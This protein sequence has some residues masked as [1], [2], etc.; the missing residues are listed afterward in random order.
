MSGRG[1]RVT[2]KGRKDV[3]M[4]AQGQ[5]VMGLP[6]F[7]EWLMRP[8]VLAQFLG[9]L[10]AGLSPED[11]A[12]QHRRAA[13]LRGLGRLAEAEAVYRALAASDP[14]DATAQAVAAILGGKAVPA[15]R[16]S[17]TPFVRLT[18]VLPDAR[19]QDLWDAVTAQPLLPAAVMET[20][21]TAKVDPTQR[22]A[23]RLEDTTAVQAWF[24][25]WL[26]AFAA[27]AGV[28]E[29]LGLPPVP[30]DRRELHVTGH[31]DGG[32][33]QM[34]RDAWDDPAS[35]T[36][37]RYV[38]YVYYFHRSPPV[39]SG[40]DLLVMDGEGA[41]ELR[42]TRLV[43]QHNSIVF[44]SARCLHGVRPVICPSADIRDWRW[45]VHGW[46]HMPD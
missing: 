42:F 5:K 27:E 33:L 40:G 14:T 6:A 31:G 12:G 38:A 13:L 36:H 28:F 1:V 3:S 46:L 45:A 23:F 32:F 34:H 37:S 20:T 43:P 39:F 22:H 19:Q 18:N 35:A 10:E 44:F 16:S 15:V 24:L 29:R 41:P 26:S 11:R 9:Q 4:L 21:V 17:V 2:D 30:L 8:Q 7:A 25:P